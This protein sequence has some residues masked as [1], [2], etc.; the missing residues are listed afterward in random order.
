MSDEERT[1][2]TSRWKTGEYNARTQPSP[3]W[4]KWAPRLPKGPALDIAC[5]NGRNAIFLA[6]LG[7]QVDAVDIASTALK[8]ARENSKKQRVKVNWIEADLD[9]YEIPENSYSLISVCFYANRDLIPKIK[10]GLKPDGFILYEHHYLSHVKVNGPENR[11]WRLR[12]NELIHQFIDFR[13]RFSE[14]GLVEDRGQ[15]LAMEQLVA[16]K[17]PVKY[18]PPPLLK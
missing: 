14:E 2:W 1:H 13:I 16:Q 9:T 10:D 6:K 15:T 3:L 17:P 11:Q 12:P 18:E 8:L 7:F 5:G 4:E